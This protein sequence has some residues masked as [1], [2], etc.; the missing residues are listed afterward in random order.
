MAPR[1]DEV[2]VRVELLDPVVARV[3][4]VHVSRRVGRESVDRPELAVPA[5]ERA[6]LGLEHTGGG[7][8]L[9]HVA[10][11]VGDVDIALGVHRDRLGKAQHALGALSDELR[12]RVRAG[13]CVRPGAP[14]GQRRH[15][16]GR[17]HAQARAQEQ[18]GPEAR[19]VREGDD[20]ASLIPA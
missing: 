3:D 8:L 19:T 15:G 5:S 7:E 13:R 12:R 20:A 1:G 17:S 14:F 18:R 16:A 2:S 10:Q 4:H 11:L 9:H 6:P